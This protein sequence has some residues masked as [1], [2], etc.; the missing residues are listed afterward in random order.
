LDSGPKSE[1]ITTNARFPNFQTPP[2]GL[3]VG[4]KDRRPPRWCR[5]SAVM[6]QRS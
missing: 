5:R 3:R 1:V 6:R 2:G 4:R